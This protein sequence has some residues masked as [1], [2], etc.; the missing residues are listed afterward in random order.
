MWSWSEEK[1]ALEYLFFTGTL[2]AREGAKRVAVMKVVLVGSGPGSYSGTRVGIAAAQGV[3]IA[4]GL[5]ADF[6]PLRAGSGAATAR[7]SSRGARVCDD[8]LRA[9][10]NRR[11]RHPRGV[12][13]RLGAATPGTRRGARVP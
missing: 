6:P 2:T 9:L 4:A 8:V 13:R 11:R 10:G 5:D 3:A 12:R 1:T 7:V